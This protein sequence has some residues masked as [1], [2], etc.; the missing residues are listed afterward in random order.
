MRML[1]DYQEACRNPPIS[2]VLQEAEVS[3]ED[4][5]SR[6]THLLFFYLLK[7]K[8]SWSVSAKNYTE[9]GFENQEE[10]TSFLFGCDQVY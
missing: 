6:E 8:R 7:Y 10:E 9:V 1:K 5:R 4:N 2:Q 3:A